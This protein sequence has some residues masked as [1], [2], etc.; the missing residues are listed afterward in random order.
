M[1][2]IKNEWRAFRLL[3]QAVP[4]VT[5]TLFIIS[6]FAMNLL[7]NKS[8][9]LPFD[10]LALDAGILVSWF[11][12]LAMD[13]LT[14]HF[15]PKA[16]TQISV[17]ATF[18]N[19]LFC[20]LFF[21]ASALPGLWGES[22]V[23]GSEAVI[24]HALDRTFGGTWYVLFG[25]TV[26]FLASAVINN[27]TNFSIGKLF[28]KNPNGAPVYFLRTYISTM[29]GQFSDNLIFALLVSHF[30]FGWSILQ[31]FSC[32]VTGMLAELLFEIIFSGFGYKVSEKWRKDKLGEEYFEFL[33]SINGETGT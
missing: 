31:C 22:F 6:V 21:L 32:A 15:G 25:S 17:L 5:V 29:I 16:A 28:K 20:F 14:K 7:A 19:L 30:F 2:K 8:L 1:E 9:S 10:W 23:E 18:F 12:F 3:L 26:A 24:N 33:K 13:T 4:T 27:F 11:S